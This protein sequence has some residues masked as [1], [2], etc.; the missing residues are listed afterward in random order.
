MASNNKININQ[1]QQTKRLFHTGVGQKSEKNKRICPSV[2]ERLQGPF[3]PPFKGNLVSRHAVLAPFLRRFLFCS[4]KAPQLR[5][6]G[7]C[8]SEPMAVKARKLRHFFF[9][10]QVRDLLPNQKLFWGTRASKWQHPEKI[11]TT[12]ITTLPWHFCRDMERQ[13]NFR[14][15]A[16]FEFLPCPEN[17]HGMKRFSYSFISH[18]SVWKNKTV[19]NKQTL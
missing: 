14:I 5:L 10:S 15:H 8:T 9:L 19:A 1:L 17:R 2:F 3:S 7:D 12:S 18:W 16:K 11:F 4:S 13:G 6:L